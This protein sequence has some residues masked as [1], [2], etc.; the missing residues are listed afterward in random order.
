MRYDNVLPGVFLERPS[1]FTARCEVAGKEEI[2]H[3][4]N[5]GRCKELLL[6]GA[7]VYLQK[8]DALGRATGFDLI[9]VQKGDRLV[10]IDS[11]MPNKV[12]REWAEGGGIKG[13]KAIKAEA[14]FGDSRL[15]FY[16]A[17]A[18]GG[19]YVEVKGVTLEEDGVALFPDAPTERGVK[20]LHE[21]CR[22]V[23]E[24]FEATVAFIIQMQGVRAFSPNDKMHPA[25]GDAL[26]EA[27]GQGV[28][29]LA[30]DCRVAPDCIVA[31]V[32]VEVRL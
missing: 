28:R 7:P 4:K 11:Q 17:T 16:V 9:A 1:R 3:V 29:V 5:T 24:G 6:P 20:H 21:L 31:D 10:N 2:C 27:A 8:A 22:C 15:D 13:L 32:P 26:R 25:F 23:R 14:A 30:L 19:L 18:G 12:F